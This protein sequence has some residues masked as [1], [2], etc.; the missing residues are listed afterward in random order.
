MNHSK[1]TSALIAAAATTWRN[2]LKMKLSSLRIYENDALVHEY[3]P[4]GD[5]GVPCLYDMV[6]K[7]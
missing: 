7:A 6:D 3:L 1:A 4:Y 2:P 5:N